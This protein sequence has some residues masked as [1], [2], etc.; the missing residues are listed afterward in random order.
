MN[1]ELEVLSDNINESV[2]TKSS[3]MP[4]MIEMYGEILTNKTYITNPAIARDEE[5]KQ[6][7]SYVIL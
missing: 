1:E 2:D 4:S 5:I 7:A 6:M 3:G